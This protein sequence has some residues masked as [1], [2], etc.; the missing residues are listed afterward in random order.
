M[1][2]RSN[3]PLDSLILIMFWVYCDRF[4]FYYEAKCNLIFQSHK[5]VFLRQ[6]RVVKCSYSCFHSSI[7]CVLTFEGSSLFTLS[8]FAGFSSATTSCLSASWT[9]TFSVY[10]FN[11]AALYIFFKIEPSKFSKL[12]IFIYSLI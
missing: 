2:G 7:F 9:L 5:A 3:F 8:K 12:F 6:I 10:C 1:C 4:Y 11:N